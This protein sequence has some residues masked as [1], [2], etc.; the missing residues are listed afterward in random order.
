M[1]QV[2]FSPPYVVHNKQLKCGPFDC[3]WGNEADPDALC[4]RNTVIKQAELNNTPLTDEQLK[5]FGECR[6][7]SSQQSQD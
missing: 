7:A 6:Q 1:T 4:L 2:E 5:M 3:N